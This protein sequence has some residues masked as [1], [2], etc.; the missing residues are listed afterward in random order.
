MTMAEITSPATVAISSRH[1]QWIQPQRL[2]QR[3]DVANARDMTM[4]EIT[5]PA[6]VAIS[7]RHDQWIQ[8]QRLLQR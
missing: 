4:A 2:L 7:S 8:P 3:H 5:S 1:D 6:T